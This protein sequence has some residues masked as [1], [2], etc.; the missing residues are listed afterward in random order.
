MTCAFTSGMITLGPD[1][2]E[3]AQTEGERRKNEQFN[4]RIH[5]YIHKCRINTRDIHKHH[6]HAT[7]I[8]QLHRTYHHT[9]N[10]NKSLSTSRREKTHW[11]TIG[12][13]SLICLLLPICHYHGQSSLVPSSLY[14]GLPFNQFE[15]K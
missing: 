11:S 10:T 9:P 1:Q 7:L 2:T 6:V 3:D 14:R 13:D 15:K 8:S 5:T 12:V 4:Q